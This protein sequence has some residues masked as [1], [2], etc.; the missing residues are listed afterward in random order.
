MES[1]AY[2]YV[3]PILE[4]SLPKGFAL[5]RTSNASLASTFP[6]SKQ[7]F[8]S[9]SLAPTQRMPFEDNVATTC[10]F[11]TSFPHLN[12]LLDQ[13]QHTVLEEEKVDKMEFD[14]LSTDFDNS[15]FKMLSGSSDDRIQRSFSSKESLLDTLSPSS[16]KGDDTSLDIAVSL[17]EKITET[18]PTKDKYQTKQEWIKRMR[19]KFCI[20]SEFEITANMI[21]ADGTLNQGYFRPTQGAILSNGQQRKWGEKERKLL[22]QGIA[23]YG[24]GHFREISEQILP[25]WSAQDLRVKTMRLMGRQNLQLYKD[26]KGNEES[27]KKEYVKNKEIGL[28]TGMWKAGTLVYD[29]DG[30]VLKMVKELD[31]KHKKRN[32]G[33]NVIDNEEEET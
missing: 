1:S 25:E 33:M 3:G 6:N 15:D 2:E 30:V 24:I 7:S 32:N 9:S 13:M 8:P 19:L 14:I 18:S 29:D 17:C 31:K 20:R 16:Q 26:W 11:I 23:S 21:H 10:S 5:Q 22:I 27:I 12:T 4:T 28:K